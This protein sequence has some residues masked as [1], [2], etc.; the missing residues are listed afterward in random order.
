MDNNTTTILMVDNNIQRDSIL[1]TQRSNEY[2]VKLKSFKPQVADITF[3]GNGIICK[4][5]K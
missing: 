5:H 3:I 1:P 2:K 4:S